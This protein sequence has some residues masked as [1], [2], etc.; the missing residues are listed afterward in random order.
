MGRGSGSESTSLQ[1][2]LNSS[3]NWT[4]NARASSVSGLSN[5]SGGDRKYDKICIWESD[6]DITCDIVDG[7]A[8]VD[9]AR[10][11][12]RTEDDADGGALLPPPSPAPR[13]AK[14]VPPPREAKRQGETIVKGHAG[15][16]LGSSWLTEKV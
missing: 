7:A 14:W 15:E 13:I 1:K 6:G 3:G 16:L 5:C 11:S 2:P 8:L 9:N 12:V 10:R 4:A